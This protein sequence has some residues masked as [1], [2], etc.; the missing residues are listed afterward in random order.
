MKYPTI[1]HEASVAVVNKMD[2]LPHLPYDIERAE[3]EIGVL[4]SDCEILRVSALK[5]DGMDEWIGWILERIRG[6]RGQ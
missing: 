3:R 4:N 2:L 1:F 5:G 6:K